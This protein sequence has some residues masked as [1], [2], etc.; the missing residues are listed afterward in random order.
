MTQEWT[1]R[2]TLIALLGT[3]AVVVGVNF[4]FIYQAE[5]TYPGED[6]QHPYL[7]GLH[8][9]QVIAARAA[10]AAMGWHATVGAVRDAKGDAVVTVTLADKAGVPVAHEALDGVLRH[11]MN[12]QLDHPV[13][14]VAKGD[15][16]YI[17]RVPHVGPGRWNVEVESTTAKEAPFR[18]DRLIWLR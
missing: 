1:G 18:A 6:V 13:T 2:H 3:F 16:T 4:Y 11:P 14:F 10:Q 5:A 12:E 17:G 9:N 7:Q 8:Y 15:G